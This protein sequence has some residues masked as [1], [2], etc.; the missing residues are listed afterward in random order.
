MAFTLLDRIQPLHARNEITIYTWGG[1]ACT[2][3]AGATRATLVNKHPLGLV[4]GDYLLLEQVQQPADG[5]R[6]RRRPTVRHV[7]RLVEVE[8][9]VDPVEGNIKLLEVTWAVADALPFDLVVTSAVPGGGW[10]TPPCARWPTATSC[11][12]TTR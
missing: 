4:P 11:S 10:A 8:P 2:L 1:V 6:Q 7:V 5:P 12:P 3:P 9:S